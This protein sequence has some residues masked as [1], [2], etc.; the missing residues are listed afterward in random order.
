MA[1]PQSRLDSLKNL[2]TANLDLAFASACGS[3]IMGSILIGF[4]QYLKV[5]EAKG[6]DIWIALSAAIP[7]AM[8]LIQIPGAIWGRGAKSYKAFVKWGGWGW[9]IFHLPFILLPFL[10][11]SNDFKLFAVIVCIGLA[12]LSGALIN[13]LYSDWLAEMVPPSSRG[14][15]F[16]RRMLYATIAS[17]VSGLLGGL[18]LDYFRKIQQEQMGFTIIFAFA[19]AMGLI[20]MYYFLRMEDMERPNA[21]RPNLK[22]GLRQIASPGKDKNFRYVL[23]FMFIFAVSQGYAGQFF[24]AYCREILDLPFT[25]IQLFGIS[26]TISTIIFIRMWGFLC[27][28]YGNKPILVLMVAGVAIT[29]LQW[30]FLH[31]E[32][33]T[34]NAIILISTHFFN[35]IVWSGVSVAHGNL[36]MATADSDDRPNYLAAV[37]AV[38][39][40]ALALSPMLG[41]VSMEFLRDWA[42]S[43]EWAYKYLFIIVIVIRVFASIALMPIREPGATS[44]RETLGQISRIRPKGVKAMRQITESRDEVA[45]EVALAQVGEGRMVLATAELAGSLDDPSPRVRRQAAKALS[46]V[47][48]ADAAE[49]L[50]RHAGN[51]P[52]LVEE[53][54]LEALGETASPDAVGILSGFLTDPRA[55]LRRAAAKALGRSGQESAIPGLLEA[56]KEAGDPDL[57]RAALQA[58]RLLEAREASQLFADALWDQHPSVRSAGAEAISELALTELAPTLR[59]SVRWFGDE[60]ASEMAYALGVVGDM[61]D[62]PEILKTGKGM[63]SLPLRRRCL[64]GAARLLGVEPDFYRLVTQKGMSQD[65]EMVKI[66]RPGYRVHPNWA[67]ALDLYTTDDEAGA[68]Q[69]LLKDR[70]GLPWDAFR[71]IHVEEA[72]LVAVL[73]V[74]GQN[75]GPD[76]Q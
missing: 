56:A 18:A 49:A 50:I 17:A 42:G 36:N 6:A 43:A 75:E 24:G 62:L 22:E 35:G 32:N 58:L 11:V 9:R 33:T 3:L 39:A 63:V 53:E 7:A 46:Q 57:R 67:E 21:V 70:D 28:R 47:P 1:K 73:A 13:P 4:I 12:A 27:D 37:A 41:W 59:E 69:A 71:Q 5:G 68:I 54:I 16:S 30:L 44:L 74:K 72:F 66:L 2:Q 64:M 15:Y 19:A 55:T 8:S 61:E 26:H 31:P 65:Q 51:H 40:I 25:V 45:R 14:W 76:S 60:A 34:A 38:S 10:G 29:P 52:D 20:S 23:L 48:S